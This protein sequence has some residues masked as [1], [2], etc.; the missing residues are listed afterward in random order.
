MVKNTQLFQRDTKG[1][2]K[3]SRRRKGQIVVS[4]EVVTDPCCSLSVIFCGFISH[5]ISGKTI[6]IPEIFSGVHGFTGKAQRN[7]VLITTVGQLPLVTSS[8]L[9]I[10]AIL[11]FR[12]GNI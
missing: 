11:K 5:L 8:W 9:L 12:I 2:L 3:I 4:Y 6:N 10:E 1:K 7:N